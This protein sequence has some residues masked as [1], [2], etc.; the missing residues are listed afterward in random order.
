MTIAKFER[1]GLNID[2]KPGIP[3]FKAIQRIGPTGIL[4]RK[5]V[6][7]KEAPAAGVFEV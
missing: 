1:S 4:K 7:G 3:C 6:T 5:G 2:A